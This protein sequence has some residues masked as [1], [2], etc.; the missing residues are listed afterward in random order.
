MDLKKC[1]M[2]KETKSINE[3]GFKSIKNN[4]REYRCK[5]CKRIAIKKDYEKNKPAY[6]A[7]TKKHNDK[8]KKI[9]KKYIDDI[10]QSPCMDCGNTFPPCAMDFDHRIA[11]E[12]LHCVSRL[13]GTVRSMKKIIEEIDKCDL[14]CSNCHR[15][16]THNRRIIAG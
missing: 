8:K 5:I 3:F 16:R 2:C 6:I 1:I 15:I 10:K 9:F 11:T 14:V 4:K 12:K 13:A 7:R